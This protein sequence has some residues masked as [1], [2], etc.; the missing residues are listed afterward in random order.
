MMLTDFTPHPLMSHLGRHLNETIVIPLSHTFTFVF[1]IA[2]LGFH[3]QCIKCDSI[4]PISVAV[5]L[6]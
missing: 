6:K 4:L 2:A 5:T 3:N 1:H